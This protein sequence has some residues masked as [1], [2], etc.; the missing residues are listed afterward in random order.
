MLNFFNGTKK[1]LVG[2][3]HRQEQKHRELDREVCAAFS[4]G[5]T[6]LQDGN[7]FTPED[8]DAL[9]TEMAEYFRGRKKQ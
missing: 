7:Y 5:N 1:R 6:S 4:Q 8:V 9:Q 2:I 3:K